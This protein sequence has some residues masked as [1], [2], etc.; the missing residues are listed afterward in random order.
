MYTIMIID[1]NKQLQSELGTLLQQEGYS[2]LTPKEFS[3]IPSLVK[4]K[5]PN[6][7]LLDINLPNQ[8]GFQICTEIRSFSSI[9]IIFITSRDTNMDELMGI[10]LGGD[11]FITKPYNTR[12]LLARIRS[13]LKR[14]Y[15]EHSFGDVISHNGISLN[16]LTSTISHNEQTIDLTK[17]ELKIL[18][19]LMSHPGKIVSRM[20]IMDYLWDNAMFINDNTLTV[21]IGR[22]RTKIEELGVSDYIK[23]KRGQGYFI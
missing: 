15:T 9:P 2:V 17:N 6:L 19:Y 13:L 12:I 22:I 20:D 5:N 3:A 23:T 11:D 1:D 8:D 14:T 21:N 4:E 7:L 10:T 18:Y 16:L